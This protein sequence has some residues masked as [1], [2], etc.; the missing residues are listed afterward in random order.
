MAITRWIGAGAGDWTDRLNWSAGVPIATSTTLFSLPSKTFTVSLDEA[1]V[2]RRVTFNAP[3]GT[4]NEFG[5][6][7]LTAT[8]FDLD[9]GRVSLRGENAFQ[10]FRLD[11]GVVEFN[12]PQAFGTGEIDLS[13]GTFLATRSTT[14]ARALDFNFSGDVVLAAAQ[15]KTLVLAPQN[16]EFGTDPSTLQ[17]GTPGASGTVRFAPLQIPTFAG[18]APLNIDVDFGTATFL[19]RN[20]TKILSQA[21][22]VDIAP[23]AT[24]NAGPGATIRNLDNRGDFNGVDRVTVAFFANSSGHIRGTSEL[25]LHG[26]SSLTG[27][28]DAT[29]GLTGKNATISF[30]SGEALG[31]SFVHLF[32]SSLKAVEDLVV[33]QD[34]TLGAKSN[35]LNPNGHSFTILGNFTLN[36]DTVVRIGSP[37]GGTVTFAN[38]VTNSGFGQNDL[39]LTGGTFKQGG[40]GLGSFD[41]LSRLDTFTI[42]RGTFDISGMIAPINDLSGGGAVTNSGLLA[43]VFLRSANAATNFTGPMDITMFGDNVLSGIIN[44]DGLFKFG[45]GEGS[46]DISQSANFNETIV[47]NPSQA[48]SNLRIGQSFAGTLDEFGAGQTIELAG[49]TGNV[50]DAVL[51]Y[52]PDA[53]NTG[54]TLNIVRE[55]V[56]FEITF[57]GD[58]G[59]ENFTL[60]RDPATQDVFV[61][62][63]PGG[64]PAPEDA[65]AFDSLGLV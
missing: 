57:L 54:G 8:L 33:T 23:G 58:Y 30:N 10:T 20:S 44:T 1:A 21:D 47:F 37:R 2:A 15:G 40:L 52:T 65:F 46:L 24:L 51:T 34:L 19:S 26:K 35:T 55:T 64:S 53:D 42:N 4:L 31:D 36:T 22:S 14:L 18:T 43:E 27:T 60:R 59:E 45:T 48:S 6:G 3:N 29:G 38:D 13:G 28:N 7:S 16:L 9:A 41:F 12:N 63:V 5:T 17:F 39:I 56:G 25:E 62:F 50:N 49:F 32:N 11:G 61:D